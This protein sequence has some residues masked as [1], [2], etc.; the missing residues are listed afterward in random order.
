MSALVRMQNAQL[1]FG[2]APLLDNAELIIE[3]GERLCIVGRNGAG[4][5]TLLKVI[6]KQVQL[7]DGQL[8]WENDAKIA[9]LPQDPPGRSEHTVFSFV[10]EAF[11]D[12]YQL[13]SSYDE[14]S[15][16]LME[17]PDSS[18]TLNKLSK[19]QEKLDTVGGW[20]LQQKIESTLTQLQLEPEAKLSEM[21][22]GWLRRV[23]MARAFV[24][25]PH[26]LLLDEPT[27]HLDIETVQWL[28]KVLQ[29]F[30][31][32]IVFISH[33]RAFIRS[34]ATRILDVDRGVL[35]SYPG[36][37]ENYLSTKEHELEVEEAQNA[38][39]DKKLA[40]EEV[41]IRQG[42]KARRTRNEGRVRTLKKL[43][44]ERAERRN[45]Q[46]QV[47]FAAGS[48]EKSGKIVWKSKDLSYQIADKLLIKDLTLNIQR[49]DKIALVGPNGI[50]KS[51]LLQL[52]LGAIEP[53]EG[54]CEQGTKL[55]VAY[56]DQH[57]AALDPELSVADNVSDGKQD[58]THQGRTRH[59]Y[60]YLQ[61]FLFSPQQ[62]RGPLKSLS[63]G[64]RN[65]VL[66][67]KI[68]L[69]DSNL[70][71]LDEPTNDLD[72]ET[73]ELLESLVVDYAGTVLVVSHDREFIDNTVSTV[74]LFEGQGRLTE[75]VGGFNE[76]K[77][78]LKN[79]PA[80]ANEKKN[81]DETGTSTGSNESDNVSSLAQPR[82]K[83]SYKLQRELE[84]LPGLI[85]E[86]EKQLSTLHVKVNEPNFFNQE[87]SDTQPV[88]EKVTELESK[89][90]KALERWD[91][92][93]QLQ[94]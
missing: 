20:E 50:G 75:V 38:L 32:A 24:T 30:K 28:E 93:E 87:P 31:G 46:G 76:V 59:I 54:E 12:A 19:V 4:K 36:N 86:L 64:E 88:L 25:E 13:L 65:R 34:L 55:N 11:T 81:E 6:Y 40:Q 52:I 77:Q 9:M 82:K 22:G 7:D 78:Y 92:L 29:N 57:R 62:A 63:G 84:E 8:H 18:E 35:R 33:D 90:D 60:S 42:I 21:S 27:N 58:V 23:A 17:N 56:Y 85:E 79:K 83:L 1:A 26:V 15:R 2:H 73:L 80:F 39:F 68:L 43:R 67:A 53:T 74:I 72:V 45:R 70:L 37:Y 10:A 61:D 69:G 3:S 5:S 48:T 41:W 51:T 16:Q 89:L 91:E 94:G 66:L 49:G 47:S 71:I 14:L 44:Q